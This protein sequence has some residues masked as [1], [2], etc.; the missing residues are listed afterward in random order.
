MLK[1]IPMHC[2]RDVQLTHLNILI[3]KKGGYYM[4]DDINKISRNEL[5][6]DVQRDLLTKDDH[7]KLNS[8][9]IDSS[10]GSTLA[11]HLN[12]TVNTTEFTFDGSKN[13]SILIDT[14]TLGAATANHDHPPQENITGNAVTTNRLLTPVNIGNAS[15]DGSKNITLDD[16]GAASIIHAHDGKYANLDHDHDGTYSATD[17]HHDDIYAPAVYDKETSSYAPKEHDHTGVH[18]MLI[19]SHD[20]YSTK[21]HDHNDAY[22]TLEHKH[23][24]IYSVKDHDHNTIYSVLDH[25]HNTIY[26]ILGHDHDDIYATKNH[27]HKYDEEIESMRKLITVSLPVS[28][29]ISENG[30]Y[31][32]SVSI[33]G[34]SKTDVLIL[35]KDTPP[36]I[37][38]A[39]NNAYNHTFAKIS[40][41]QASDGIMTFYANSSVDSDITICLA[42]GKKGDGRLLTW[43]GGRKRFKWRRRLRN[44]QRGH[45]YYRQS[46]SC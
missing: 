4:F 13:I 29:W 17:H 1:D 44:F 32:Q 37:S 46:S 31:K 23:D 45:Y 40:G 7:K 14:M 12:L 22:S 11:H 27:T 30:L 3:I 41:G 42:T 26:S 15:F 8:L 19:H 10:G 34:L 38:E 24:D 9:V 6:S 18:A 28:G 39:E 35:F 33:D 5:A 20:S 16:I 36:N 21:D 2:S 25:D 43:G